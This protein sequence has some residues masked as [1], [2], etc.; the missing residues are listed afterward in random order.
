MKAKI[1]IRECDWVNGRAVKYQA[2][3]YWDSKRLTE[4]MISGLPQK[5]KDKAKAS[6]WMTIA[7]FKE[8]IK[9]VE[10]LSH[11]ADRINEKEEKKTTKT[12]EK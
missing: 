1:E 8:L 3:A 12:K 10:I 7:Q 5:T 2:H 11:C 4:P 6:L 9:G